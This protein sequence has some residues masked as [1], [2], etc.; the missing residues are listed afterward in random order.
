MRRAPAAPSF[1]LLERGRQSSVA[2]SQMRS[3]LQQ[4]K[5]C[6]KESDEEVVVVVSRDTGVYVRKKCNLKLF[7]DS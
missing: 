1:R 5:D 7:K 6:T 2:L 4:L 3:L